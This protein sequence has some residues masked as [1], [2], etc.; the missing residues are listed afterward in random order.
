M[1]TSIKP[2]I[3]S[4][5]VWYQEETPLLAINNLCTLI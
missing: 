1:T 4:A 2:T 3:F 5:K